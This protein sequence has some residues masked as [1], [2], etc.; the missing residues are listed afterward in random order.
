MV[1]TGGC[2][3]IEILDASRMTPR[4]QIR[5]VDSVD[6]V[7]GNIEDWQLLF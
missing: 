7:L 2:G 6:G 3:W 1:V 4:I 5:E